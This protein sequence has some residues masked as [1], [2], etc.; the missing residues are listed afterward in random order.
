[1]YKR[2][3]NLPKNPQSSLFLWGPRQSG[4]TTLLKE[5][6]G[7]AYYI[8]L[9]KNENLI[10]YL[11]APQTFR[12]E[13]RAR[14]SDQLIVLDEIQKVPS[15]LDEI[16][17][18]IEEERRVF[19]LC[20]SSARKLRRGHSNLLGGRALR[21]ELFGLT[22]LEIREEFNLLR[23]I[24]TGPLPGHYT[25][26][27]PEKALRS[28]VE[29]YLR[30]EVLAEGLVRRLSTFSDFLR[31]AAIGDT[32]V[33]NLSNIAQ[34]SGVSVVTVK[35]H[36]QILVDTLLGA[37]LPSYTRRPKRRTQRAP[38]FYFRDVGV[39][40]HLARRG[41]LLEGGELFGKAFEI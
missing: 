9:L 1:M 6:Y 24:N 13:V 15:L 33:V 36:Y 38:K 29:D 28:Y 25:H 30:E 2:S 34:E 14:P 4:K 18:L 11:K 12:E 16:H 8:D 7:E 32:E 19:V 31:I 27:S 3:L 21:Y 26:S 35:S 20:G 39:V 10:R 23:F 41:T 40:N 5:T 22:R 17:S 37:F